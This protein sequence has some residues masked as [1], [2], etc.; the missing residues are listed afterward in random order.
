VRLLRAYL[1]L[2]VAA[3]L[4]ALVLRRVGINELVAVARGADLWLVLL[5]FVIANLAI[6]P[7]IRNWQQ[8]LRAQGHDVPFTALFKLYFVGT[9]FNNLL[10]SN[11]GGDVVRSYEVG[12]RIG[13]PATAFASVFVERFIGLV[14]L[15]AFA[16][17]AFLTQFSALDNSALALAMVA[18]GGGLVALGWLALDPTASAFLER[19]LP[20]GLQRMIV[21]ARK[22]QSALHRYRGR[23]RLL[24]SSFG[25]SALF[26][27]GAVLYGFVAIAAFHQPVD[28]VGTVFIVPI[29]MVVAMMPVSFNGVGLQEW[30]AVLLFPTIGVPA[31]AA[32]SGILL[33][34]ALTLVTSLVGGL[35]YL[36]LKAQH[37][38]RASC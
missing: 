1:P 29:T 9:F 20:A 32:L 25:Y 12:Q 33:I 36:Q 22:V 34:R 3:T 19:S 21:K 13:D 7:K 30:A 35:F 16:T 38:A 37:A 8:L 15:V 23:P 18:A 27:A 11:V 10:P 26:D 17:V 24:A 5:A 4:L 2:A 14:V 6:L 28:F 31:S